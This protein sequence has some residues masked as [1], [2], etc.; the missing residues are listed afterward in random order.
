MTAPSYHIWS[1]SP[2]TTHQNSPTSEST[3]IT[4]QFVEASRI[5][6]L[7]WSS[8]RWEITK[9]RHPLEVGEVVY[10][11]R[12]GEGEDYLED[13]SSSGLGIVHGVLGFVGPYAIIN[14]QFEDGDSFPFEYPT[15]WI[16]TD[17]LTIPLNHAVS[18]WRSRQLHP[19]FI[20][21]TD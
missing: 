15:F 14:V 11:I 7:E 4:Q 13:S 12:G 8:H 21:H 9:V 20:L 6:G 16:H 19:S 3:V 2:C 10:L 18:A 1:L 5:T 17:K